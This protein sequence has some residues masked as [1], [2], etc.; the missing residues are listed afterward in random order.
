MSSLNRPLSGDVLVFDLDA[1][2]EELARTPAVTAGGRQA[3]TLLKDGG[4]RV[5]LIVLGAGA[6]I[7]E[8]HAD[9]PITVHAIDGRIAFTV[10]GETHDLEPGR[11]LSARA[12][13]PHSVRSESGGAFLLTV[14]LPGTSE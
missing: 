7:P 6:V 8:H 14:C 10:G 9:G 3:R 1:A 5:T 12:G 4:L 11:V 13:L 2:R